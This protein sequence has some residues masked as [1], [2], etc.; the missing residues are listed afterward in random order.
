MNILLATFWPIPLLG[1]VWP[2]M[3]QIKHGLEQRGHTV[4]LLGN[5]SDGTKY[6]IVN[7]GRE[8]RKEFLLPMLERNLNDKVASPLNVDAWIHHAELDRYC[9]E[10]SAAYFGIDHYD[11]IHTQDVVSTLAMSRVKRKHVPLVANIHGSLAKE[12]MLGHQDRESPMWKYYWAM[13]HYGATAADV[14]ITSTN[15]MRNILVQEFEVPEQQISTF[16]YGLDTDHFWSVSAQGTDVAAPPG[17]KV[18]ICPARLTYIKGL[19]YLI[20]A[21]Q[22]L[23]RRRS[24]WVCWI[25]GDGEKKEE[26]IQEAFAA[27]I[28]EDIV[29]LGH[30]KDVP[31]L[32]QQADIFVHPSIQDNMPFSVMEAQV[33]GL[34]AAVS[35]A[36]GLPEMVQH[37]VTGFVSSVGD[38]KTLASHLEYLLADDEVR[39]RMG[40]A[41]KAWGTEHWSKDL[42]IGRYLQVYQ[43]TSEKVKEKGGVR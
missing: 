41:A 34:P 26:L 10:L 42:M 36:G 38:I 24:D 15:W 2:F 35:N 39:A 32:L 14:T 20:A 22:L 9:M 4:D 33:S 25:A 21:L 6:H 5:A 19:S 17:K 28:G 3:L 16:P 7:Q 40:A 37:E 18:I 8:L 1:G 30:R 13:E 27:G 29:F 23:K 31:A 11:L 12:V 43:Q